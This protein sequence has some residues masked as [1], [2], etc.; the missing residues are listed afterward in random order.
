MRRGPYTRRCA[1][2]RARAR[3]MAWRSTARAASP[4]FLAE[5]ALDVTTVSIA[6]VAPDGRWLAFTQTVRRDAYGTDYRHDGD[7]TYVHATPVRL[8]VTDARGGQRT[9]VFADK[10]PV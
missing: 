10:R 5:D 2:G 7:P 4:V 9:P 1:C 6:D 8:W 3:L